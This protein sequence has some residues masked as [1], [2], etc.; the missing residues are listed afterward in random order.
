MEYGRPPRVAMDHRGD[1]VGVVGFGSMWMSEE[2][3][4]ERERKQSV[5]IVSPVVL[6]SSW[7]RTMLDVACSHVLCVSSAAPWLRVLY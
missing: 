2:R 6:R 1:D 4:R 3:E 5:S 7:S